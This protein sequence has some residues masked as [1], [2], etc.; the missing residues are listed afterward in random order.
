MRLKIYFILSI[1]T[2]LILFSCNESEISEFTD[3][4]IVEAYLNPG[5]TPVVKIRRQIPFSSGVAYSSDSIK[6]LDVRIT[7]NNIS[8]KL[9]CVGDTEYVS[10]SLVIKEGERYDLTFTFN[11]K[12]VSTIPFELRR[13]TVL[14]IDLLSALA[15]VIE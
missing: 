3:T 10:N 5:E 6:N 12:S 11:N 14:L 4:P 15:P 2:T 1:L 9:T 13:T 7:N 8:Y